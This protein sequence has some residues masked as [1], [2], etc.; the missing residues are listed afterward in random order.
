MHTGR[1]CQLQLALRY[2]K[3]LM[4][5]R[6]SSPGACDTSCRC[7]KPRAATEPFE[8]CNHTVQAAA[9]FNSAEIKQLFK[10]I[11]WIVWD[12]LE[13]FFFF[14]RDSNSENRFWLTVDFCEVTCAL[15]CMIRENTCLTYCSTFLKMLLIYFLTLT[16]FNIEIT[17]FGWFKIKAC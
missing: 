12:N 9:G 13:S 4:L 10:D 17:V 15:Q 5:E 14:A 7:V 6:G 3:A 2:L 16:T 8:H 11:Y 1:P